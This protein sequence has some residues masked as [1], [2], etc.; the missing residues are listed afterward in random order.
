M[1]SIFDALKKM[2]SAKQPEP[3]KE[4][5]R[6]QFGPYTPKVEIE[7]GSEEFQV[8]AE[9]ELEKIVARADSIL[10]KIYAD[11]YQTCVEW[12]EE[13]DKGYPVTEEFVK[14]NYSVTRILI[15]EGTM[16]EIITQLWGGISKNRYEDLLG[17]HVHVTELYSD[18]EEITFTLEG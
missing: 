17:D 14:A 12:E 10:K 18:S 1:R 6:V 8:K 16:G 11:A 9:R 3:E 4:E 13:D 7:Y 5:R 15:T 2:L